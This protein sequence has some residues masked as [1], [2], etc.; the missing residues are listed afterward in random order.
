MRVNLTPVHKQ[1]YSQI[2][3][4]GFSFGLLLPPNKDA[5][6]PARLLTTWFECKDYL[7]D[8]FWSENTKQK[9]SCCGLNW[10]PGRIN[11]RASRQFLILHSEKEA[12]LY[13]RLEA[14]QDFLRP[15]D[16]A[17]GW[18]P[19]IIHK[20]ENEAGKALLNALVVEAD[21]EWFQ[22]AP[23]ISSLTSLIRLARDF[24]VNG[25]VDAYL[26]KVGNGGKA[27]PSPWP[28]NYSGKELGRAPSTVP[29]LRALLRGQ[30]PIQSWEAIPS[31]SGAHGRGVLGCTTY[32]TFA[33]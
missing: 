13:M 19:T 25:D 11:P 4:Y 7:Q 26:K 6:E 12:N 29:K 14:L 21:G 2:R 17:N 10:E 33:D 9:G 31:M 18:T 3:N 22:S 32:P 15:F 16:K 20:V 28:E 24:P 27:F 5:G 1:G 30:R 8:I 23:L